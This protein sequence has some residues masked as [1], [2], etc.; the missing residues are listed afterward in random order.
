[1]PNDR[2]IITPPSLVP[3]LDPLLLRD[4]LR[5]K[6][7]RGDADADQFKA[8]AREALGNGI[9]STISG[10]ARTVRAIIAQGGYPAAKVDAYAALLADIEA[11]LAG[12]RAGWDIA[13]A[14]AA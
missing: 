5:M 9:D 6:R 4:V 8:V 1:M 11:V 13:I 14:R 2:M 7:N 3:Q 12:D 10:A